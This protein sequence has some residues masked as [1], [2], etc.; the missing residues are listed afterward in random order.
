MAAGQGTV[1]SAGGNENR[2]SHRGNL[3]ARYRVLRMALDMQTP[4]KPKAAPTGALSVP[5]TMAELPLS[6]VSSAF[7]ALCPCSR[8]ELTI[9]F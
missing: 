6:G 4:Q 2:G 8:I 5:K 7:L 9:C 1:A 3:R